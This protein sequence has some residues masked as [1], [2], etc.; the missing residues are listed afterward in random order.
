MYMLTS[1]NKLCKEIKTYIDGFL[2][3]LKTISSLFY[4]LQ[5]QNGVTRR[6]WKNTNKKI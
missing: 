2:T 1:L 3:V 6:T 5:Y 4:K